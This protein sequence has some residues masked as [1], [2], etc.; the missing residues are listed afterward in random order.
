M[1]A[2]KKAPAG[3]RATLREIPVSHHD[4]T[5]A[6]TKATAALD[7]LQLADEHYTGEDLEWMRTI[8]LDVVQQELVRAKIAYEKAATSPKTEA[9]R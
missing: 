6:I 5:L 4:V 8:C 7:R 2:A 3:R 1:A 9:A